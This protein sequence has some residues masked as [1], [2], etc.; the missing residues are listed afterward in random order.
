MCSLSPK[1][2]EANG[3]VT[4]IDVLV[5]ESVGHSYLVKII[6][7]VREVLEKTGPLEVQ[8]R[9]YPICLSTLALTKVMSPTYM[10][11]A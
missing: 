3:C 4:V 9:A 1:D 7:L 10:T 6:L 11:S 2:P 8:R 5:N